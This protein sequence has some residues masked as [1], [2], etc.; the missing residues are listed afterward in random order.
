LSA[1]AQ[2][3]GGP[4]LLPRVDVAPAPAPQSDR[5]SLAEY[6][7]RVLVAVGIVVLAVAL[8]KVA[9]LAVVAFAGVV[10]AVLVRAIAEPLARFTGLG[11]RLA[12]AIVVLALAA[13][14]SF[15]FWLIGE[16]LVAQ[17]TQL[18]SALPGA[19]SGMRRWA[20]QWPAGRALIDSL[21]SLDG[22]E[23]A[24]RVA[25]FAMTTV[26]AITNL[27]VIL[28]LGVYLAVDPHLYRRGVLHLV[29]A[30][31]RSRAAQAL[32]SAGEGLR[33][34][35]LS[36][37][38]AMVAV[39]LLTGVALWA[40]GVPFALSLGV[41]AGLLE[42]VP[43]VGPVVAAIPGI[44]LAFSAS[45]ETALYAAVAY[46]AIQQIEGNVLMPIAQRWAVSLPPA[47]GMLAVVVF[48]VLLG[49][50]GVILAVPLMVVAMILVQKLY[51][52]A[53]LGESAT[54]GRAPTS[55]AGG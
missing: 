13:L 35:L 29:P 19:L 32:D 23:S 34:W 52:E 38:V 36:Q 48:G 8:W 31:A 15:A 11:D 42:F 27:V 7:R 21:G 25:G 41:I 3:P 33:K 28:F 47:L 4:A 6:T 22:L 30:A 50:P 55:G 1:P 17:V 18:W 45:P 53:A 46:L 10:A 37:F 5:L 26:G 14:V 51:I 16:T 2:A 49:L 39:G 20:E 44:L 54:P 12:V 9:G 24:T 43:F 40:L